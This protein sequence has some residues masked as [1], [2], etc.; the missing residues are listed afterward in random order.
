MTE[1]KVENAF[2]FFKKPEAIE[3]TLFLKSYSIA[4]V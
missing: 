2:H 1:V 3:V 4:W